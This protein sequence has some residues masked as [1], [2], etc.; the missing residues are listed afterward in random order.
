MKIVGWQLFALGSAVFAALTAIL[1]KIGVAQINSNLATFIRTIVI[2]LVTAALVSWRGEWE[3]LNK[4]SSR[5]LLFLVLS[6]VATGLSWLC[7]YR[8]LKEGPASAVAPIDKLSVVLVILFAALFLGEPLTWKTAV[9]GGL[10]LAGV[11]TIAWT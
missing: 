11:L 9:G 7:Y 8:A 3:P 10:I 4:M 1:G 6:G 2:L 5:S